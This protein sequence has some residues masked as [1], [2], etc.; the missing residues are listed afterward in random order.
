[1]RKYNL[2]FFIVVFA[3]SQFF[4][5]RGQIKFYDASQFQLIGKISDSTETHFER[6]P[7][8]LKNKSR[9]A[10][11]SLGKHT[12]GLAVRFRT[13]SQS[14]TLKWEVLKNYSMYHMAPTGIRGLDLYCWYNN[15]WM[16][17]NTAKAKRKV[18][19]HNIIS[20]MNG[21]EREYMLYLPLFDGVLSLF[22][23]IDSLATITNPKLDLP[24]RNNPIIVYGT[25]ITQGA[26]ATRPGMSYTNILTRKL[27]R[28]CINLGFNGNGKLD[29]DIAEVMG[30]R[31]NVKLYILDFVPNVNKQQIIDKLEKFI[32]L[33]RE[34]NPTVPILLV[35][36]P[37]Y[38]QSLLDVKTKLMITEKNKTLFK[39]YEELLQKGVS[40]LHYLSSENVT[41]NDNEAT[42][43]G[44]HFTDLGF[45]RYSE[46]L[47]CKIKSILN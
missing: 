21:E 10:I 5:L 28:E 11:W 20:N 3:T 9:T 31:N 35:E 30:Q 1:M 23:G 43:D 27:N 40:N 18:N 33:L 13:N 45:K 37:M 6:L 22:I 29:Y 44:I 16:F 14:I 38:T 8:S 15:S 17:V 42:V 24:I 12:S 39:K 25:S 19:E 41:G 2:I 34:N 32:S 36:S 4:H 7:Y 46:S 26:C 47:I